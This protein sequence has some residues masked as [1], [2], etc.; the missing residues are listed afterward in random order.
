MSKPTSPLF[1][2]IKEAIESKERKYS[3]ST[4]KLY[5]LTIERIKWE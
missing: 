5:S 1:E 2:K 4:L 3:G